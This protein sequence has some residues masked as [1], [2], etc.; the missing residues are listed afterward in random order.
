M[1]TP[2]NGNTGAS[3]ALGSLSHIDRSQRITSSFASI[4][5]VTSAQNESVSFSVADGLR[6]GVS[7]LQ[8][9]NSGLAVGQGSVS[10]A[11]AATQRL[12]DGLGHM[13]DVL[14]RMSDTGLTDEARA[15]LDAEY[16]AV[17]EEMGQAVGDADYGGTNLIAGNSDSLAITLNPM[18]DE[19]QLTSF[20]LTFSVSEQFTGVQDAQSAQA[21]LDGGL[22]EA[23]E[24]VGMAQD[25]LAAD[26][27]LLSSQIA[28]NKEL[29]DTTATALGRLVDADLARE[30]ARL[31]TVGIQQQ[32]A[33]Q[34]LNI[35]NHAPM[36]LLQLFR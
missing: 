24:M 6:S 1:I 22:V 32:L 19:V 21:L 4:Q 15:S 34:N 18:G 16:T 27:R 5:P 28:F 9:V 14:T 30:S 36:A 26:S 35:A 23:E 8:A 2:L 20:D 29:E 11:L 7:S 17:L 31:Q 3:S 13:R 25:S 12:S 33:T 10:V